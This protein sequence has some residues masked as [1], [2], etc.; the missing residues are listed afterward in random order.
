M[1]DLSLM[2]QKIP[3]TSIPKMVS[4]L[5]QFELQ[6]IGAFNNGSLAYWG[7]DMKFDVKLTLYARGNEPVMAVGG[8]VI[9]EKLGAAEPESVVVEGARRTG[10]TGKPAT[11]K[12]KP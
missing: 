9:G 12:G 7:V 11:V 1:S 2:N 6:K 4:D 5:I 10:L 8:G 3:A